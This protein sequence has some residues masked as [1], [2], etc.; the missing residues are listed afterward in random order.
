MSELRW[1]S[2]RPMLPGVY[3]Y[4]R[5]EPVTEARVLEFDGIHCRFTNGERW[6]ILDL[7]GH[8]AGPLEPPR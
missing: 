3:W 2:R 4:R 6:W 7:V 5:T 1:T 8:W